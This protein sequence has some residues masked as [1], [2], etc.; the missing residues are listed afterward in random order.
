MCVV[1]GA[2]FLLVFQSIFLL[3]LMSFSLLFIPIFLAPSDFVLVVLHSD[4]TSAI[5][6]VSES[7]P[8]ERGAQQS[9]F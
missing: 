7:V 3:R 6:A 2:V 9:L 4:P 5:L 1:G 8:Q